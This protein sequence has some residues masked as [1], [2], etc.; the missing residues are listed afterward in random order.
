[1]PDPGFADDD[2]DDDDDYDYD[3]DYDYDYGGTRLE[4][5]WRRFR[6]CRGSPGRA[7]H[8]VGRVSLRDAPYSHPPSFR[9][10]RG[11]IS[12]PL[13]RCPTLFDPIMDGMLSTRG[14]RHGVQQA[15]W[16][17]KVSLPAGRGSG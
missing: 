13:P 4:G 9:V 10:F 15:Q 14:N 8:T 6:R 3:N 7:V 5:P 12:P 2:D 16:W 17:L 11:C 1:M